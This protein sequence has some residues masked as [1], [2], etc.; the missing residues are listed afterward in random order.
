M[1]KNFSYKAIRPFLW[2]AVG[3]AIVI[4]CN[5][6]KISAED[7]FRAEHGVRPLLLGH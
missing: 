1:I 2:M 4:A 7:K 3:A 6:I 5:Y